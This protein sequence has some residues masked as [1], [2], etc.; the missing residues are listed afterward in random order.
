MLYMEV[1]V[2]KLDLSSPYVSIVSILETQSEITK[3]FLAKAL[4][5]ENDPVIFKQY[6][7]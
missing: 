3:R 6:Y 5:N 4:S 7:Y 1:F 2:L